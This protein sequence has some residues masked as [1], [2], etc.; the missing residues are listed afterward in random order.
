[1]RERARLGMALFLLSEAVFFFMLIA[2]F[3]YFRDRRTAAA[4]LRFGPS[5]LFTICLAA[6]SA[7]MWRAA[8]SKARSLLASTLTLGAVFLVWQAT[9]TLQLYRR[10]ITISQSLFGT[11]FFTLT[12]FHGLHV[13]IGI[14]L[15][16]IVMGLK[17]RPGVLEAV[18]LYWY[19]VGVVWLAIFAVVYLWTFL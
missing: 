14:V 15:I 2:A 9:E 18:A 3:L 6:S 12:G 7:T 1:M 10:N 5:I 17:D 19:F 8:Q 11:T 13:L 16:G 4:T